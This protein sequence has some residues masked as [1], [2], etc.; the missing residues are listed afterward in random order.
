MTAVMDTLREYVRKLRKKVESYSSVEIWSKIGSLIFLGICSGGFMIQVVQISDSYFKYETR[1][2]NDISFPFKIPTPSMSICF[3]YG[4]IIDYDMVWEKYPDANISYEGGLEDD[5]VALSNTL[6]IKDLFEM[7]PKELDLYLFCSMRKKESFF[8]QDYF[9]DNCTQVFRVF[10]FYIL[11]Y[12]CYKF[13]FTEVFSGRV[14]TFEHLAFTL[15]NPGLIYE[16]SL[17]LTAF[18][19]ADYI[20][21]VIHSPKHYPTDSIGFAP[22]L[23]RIIDK[24]TGK[25][26]YNYF[27]ID[28]YGIEQKRLPPPYTTECR[29]YGQETADNQRTCQIKCKSEGT[30][31]NFRKVMFNHIQSSPLEIGHMTEQLYLRNQTMVIME[32]LAKECERQC[33]ELACFDKMW[34]TTPK[35]VPTE[36]RGLDFRVSSPKHMYYSTEHLP[37]LEF[38][39]YFVYVSS[40]F[41]LW[42]GI[43]V[44]Q[45]NPFPL[46]IRTIT[47]WHEKRGEKEGSKSANNE[48]NLPAR[49][50]GTTNPGSEPE[51]NDR[52]SN[53]MRTF[54]ERN[55]Q[56][57]LQQSPLYLHYPTTSFATDRSTSYDTD[58]GFG[59]KDKTVCPDCQKEKNKR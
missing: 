2:V 51:R 41:G 27:D 39:D 55:L 48:S 33:N 25:G 20:R 29:D 19:L 56:Q 10:K 6:T 1:I 53:R 44:W 50:T 38:M 32:G 49:F 15:D 14:H 37:K 22:T 31:K 42:F 43:S 18:L 12:V 16:I 54:T 23:R 26:K 3:R 24:E 47:Q 17:N 40:C 5:F 4:D 45:V 9:D 7:T 28:F 57:P 8:L 30:V 52:V 11:N 35:K 36:P 46:L 58:F 13:N 21:I 34:V 59:R